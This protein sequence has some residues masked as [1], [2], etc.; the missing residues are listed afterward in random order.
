MSF[1]EILYV[2]A[3]LVFIG[4]MFWGL[5]RKTNADRTADPSV[6]HLTLKSIVRNDLSITIPSLLI[7]LLLNFNV[8][9]GKLLLGSSIALSYAIWWVSIY[10]ILTFIFIIHPIRSSLIRLTANSGNFN[11]K[12]YRSLSGIWVMFGI[13]EL[14]PLILVLLLSL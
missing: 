3:V 10:S 5:V 13:M 11:E 6:M 2:V 8:N 14:G 7:V 12:K 4:N 9:M 1:T